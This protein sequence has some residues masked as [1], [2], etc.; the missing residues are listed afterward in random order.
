MHLSQLRNVIMSEG[1]DRARDGGLK[2]F[3]LLEDTDQ[4]EGGVHATPREEIACGSPVG[5]KSGERAEGR[6]SAILR[7]WDTV[8]ELPSSSIRNL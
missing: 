2:E 3:I 6:L 8:R 4:V 7:E 1:I 5:E